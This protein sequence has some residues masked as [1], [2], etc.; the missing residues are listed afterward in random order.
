MMWIFIGFTMWFYEYPYIYDLARVF[1][2]LALS[3]YTMSTSLA[4]LVCVSTPFLFGHEESPSEIT[5]DDSKVF[6]DMI[7]EE[8]Y[9]F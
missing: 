9:E 6:N 5:I 2:F 4:F 1:G 3:F 8:E 7:V